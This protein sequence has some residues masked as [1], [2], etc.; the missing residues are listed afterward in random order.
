MGRMCSLEETVLPLGGHWW[1]AWMAWVPHAHQLVIPGRREWED[2]SCPRSSQRPH[3]PSQGLETSLGP[4]PYPVRPAVRFGAEGTFPMMPLLTTH[5]L[6]R[7]VSRTLTHSTKQ[8]RGPVVSQKH[9][10]PPPGIT[11]PNLGSQPPHSHNP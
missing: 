9:T 6:L 3:L 2:C 10:Q 11:P 4:G 1:A 5:Q 7:C 8:L